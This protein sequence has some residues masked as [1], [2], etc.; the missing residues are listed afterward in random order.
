MGLEENV[1]EEVITM[2]RFNSTFIGAEIQLCTPTAM[3]YGLRKV[4]L[5]T[6]VTKIITGISSIRGIIHLIRSQNFS[7]YVC[8]SGGK[9]Y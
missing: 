8:E 1:E 3:S 7:T 9:K 4:R 6:P 2:Y 5:M